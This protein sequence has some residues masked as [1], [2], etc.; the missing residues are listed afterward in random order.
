LTALEAL[1]PAC[2]FERMTVRPL[3]QPQRSP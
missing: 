1:I 3:T 2:P